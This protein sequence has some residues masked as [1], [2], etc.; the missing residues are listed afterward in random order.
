MGVATGWT[1]QTTMVAAGRARGQGREMDEVR[2]GGAFVGIQEGPGNGFY[3]SRVYTRAREASE[4]IGGCRQ[5]HVKPGLVMLLASTTSRE[6][7][8]ER[9]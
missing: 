7:G 2:C 6:R 8:D 3:V 1:E 9:G 4:S 5:R